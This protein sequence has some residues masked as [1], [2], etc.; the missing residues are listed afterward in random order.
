MSVSADVDLIAMDRLG[1]LAE[2]EPTS[3]QFRVLMLPPALRADVPIAVQP[4][5]CLEAAAQD[6]QERRGGCLARMKLDLAGEY[7]LG[8]AARRGECARAALT[9]SRGR[10][11]GQEQARGP[12]PM[13]QAG[14]EGVFRL[15]CRDKQGNRLHT[16]ATA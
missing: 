6:L 8:A 9:S 7:V 10:R 3:W 4:R 15:Y 13:G 16:A 5:R 11:R 1:N 2:S 12:L 14:V